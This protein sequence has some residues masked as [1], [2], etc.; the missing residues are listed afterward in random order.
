[1]GRKKFLTGAALRKEAR[2]RLEVEETKFIPTI[3]VDAAPKDMPETGQG[4]LEWMW[5]R[6]EKTEGNQVVLATP[7]DDP[8]RRE[9]MAL[10]CATLGLNVVFERNFHIREPNSSTYL[11]SGTIDS[12]RE[13]LHA[14]E[15]DALVLDA[16]LSPGQIKNIE[17]M[18]KKPCVDRQGVILSIFD[19][20]DRSKQAKLQVELARLKYLQPR[21]A[22]I[23]EGLSRQRGGK[24]GKGGRGQ[25][26][27]RL[28]LDRRSL[29]ERVRVLTRKLKEAEKAFE[30]QSSRR[31]KFP[32][33]ALVGYTNA[34][35]SSLMRRLT[36]ADVLAQNRL[37]STLD[38]TVRP[39]SPPTDP[40][41]LMSDTV[42]FVRDLPHDLVASFKSTLREAL[43]ADV[44][45]HVVDASH[46]QWKLQIETTDAV[47]EELGVV[48]IPKILVLNKIDRL[49]D[50]AKVRQHEAI[51]WMSSQKNYLK[52]LTTSAKT[53]EGL[54]EVRDYLMEHLKAQNPAWSKEIE[55]E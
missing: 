31:S 23:W 20:H 10:L 37:F 42:G 36:K 5:G 24:G 52:I 46:P 51:R 17:D 2:R 50:V 39:L 49:Q 25:G 32:R 54:A 28:E 8:S 35:K 48:E 29:K 33:A 7:E 9:E 44:I 14:W 30:T 18:L 22:G 4:R 19:L 53:G 45:L 41:I 21:L 38:T 55:C 12:L 43:E 11:G 26:E 13:D 15:A 47:L 40:P 34:G 27:T 16:P 6:F 1:M 3:S